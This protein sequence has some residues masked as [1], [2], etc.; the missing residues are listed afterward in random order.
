MF[1]IWQVEEVLV[2]NGLVPKCLH[3]PELGWTQARNLGLRMSLPLGSGS[4][5]LELSPA[6][7]QGHEQGFEWEAQSGKLRFELGTL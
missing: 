4:K 5:A 6:A 7:A 2:S 1:I 3:Q